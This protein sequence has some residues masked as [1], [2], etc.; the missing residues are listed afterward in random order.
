V[1][2]NEDISGEAQARCNLGATQYLRGA[3]ELALTQFQR[4]VD[5]AQAS[6]D[7]ALLHLSMVNAGA[8]LAS[9]YETA[10]TAM[11]QFKTDPNC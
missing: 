7:K 1:Q 10:L 2:K 5:I 6:N 11:Q 8:A 4:L 9:T 3:P